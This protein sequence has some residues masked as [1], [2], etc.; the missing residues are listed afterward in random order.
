MVSLITPTKRSRRSYGR[1]VLVLLLL[2]AVILGDL[3]QWSLELMA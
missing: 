2:A 1:V 3:E